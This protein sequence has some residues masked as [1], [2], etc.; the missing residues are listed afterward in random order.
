[1]LDSFTKNAIYEICCKHTTFFQILFPSYSLHFNWS[2]DRIQNDLLMCLI[3]CHLSVNLT[4]YGNS[5]NYFTSTI[6]Y[7]ADKTRVCIYVVCTLDILFSSNHNI[8]KSLYGLCFWASD[9]FID[10][11]YKNLSIKGSETQKQR[12]HEL[13]WMFWFDEKSITMSK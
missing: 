10:R 2:F 6:W 5:K 8:H 1:M 11:F 12:W 7:I 13:L 4:P 3:I 9:P